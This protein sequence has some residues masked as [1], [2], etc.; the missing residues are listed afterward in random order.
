MYRKGWFRTT[1]KLA[2]CKTVSKSI[3]WKK[4]KSSNKK[5]NLVLNRNCA[6][7]V[8]TEEGD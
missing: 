6:V 2:V 1:S 4:Y 8:A 7:Y 5:F 3:V